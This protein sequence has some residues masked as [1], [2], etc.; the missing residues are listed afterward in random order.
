MQAADRLLAGEAYHLDPSRPVF[1]NELGKRLSPKAATNAFARLAKKA[2]I[3]ITSL[4]ST[5][6]TAAMTHIRNNTDIRTVAS[7]LGQSNPTVTLNTYARV[8]QGA[9]RGA[10]DMYSGWLDDAL[11]GTKKSDL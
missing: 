8:V 7:M 10:A 11:S 5:R 6:H 9:K 2:G 1:T 3:T 4:H